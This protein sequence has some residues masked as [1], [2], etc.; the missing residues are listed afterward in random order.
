M[1]LTRSTLALMLAAAACEGRIEDPPRHP[2]ITV[3]AVVMVVDEGFDLSLPVLRG[4]VAASYTMVCHRTL[5]A[6]AGS[7]F[8]QLKPA[9]LAELSTSDETCSLREGIRALPNP[10]ADLEDQRLRWNDA[11]RAGRFADSGTLAPMLVERMLDRPV[12]GTAVAALIAHADPPIPL[13]LVERSFA[14]PVTLIDAQPSCLRQDAIDLAVELLE[15]PEIRRAYLDRP[16]SSLDRALSA[17]RA[18]HRV[19]VVNESYGRVTRA[20]LERQQEERGCPAVA[21]GRYLATKAELDRHRA[22]RHASSSPGVLVV[23]AAGND[24]AALDGPEDSAECRIGHPGQLLVGSY[25]PDDQRSG[26]SNFGRCVD[27]YAPGEVV[28][29]LPGDWLFPMSGT[30]FAAPLVARLVATGGAGR[31]GARDAA[32]A[33]RR[34]DGALPA[35]LFPPELLRGRAVPGD[36]ATVSDEDPVW[37]IR[38][39]EAAAAASP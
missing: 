2:A 24:G 18:R 10:F 21:A 17:V 36:L 9:L 25:G 32:L 3:P 39:V 23:K 7:T 4:A 35:G 27:L 37:P 11:V 8:A 33:L 12:H 19:A 26:F 30:S 14:A 38:W 16:P 1:R 13:V 28:G 5:P 31:S 34:E 20:G 15:D 6:A 22:E 29:R